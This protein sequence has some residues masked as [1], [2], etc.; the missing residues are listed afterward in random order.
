[1]FTFGIDLTY[2]DFTNL[3]NNPKAFLFGINNQVKLLATIEFIII[4]KTGIIKELL[5]GIMIF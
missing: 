2:K 4:L 5:V 1:M 3:L